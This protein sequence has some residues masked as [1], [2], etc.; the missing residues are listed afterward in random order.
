MEFDRLE[1]AYD[2][3]QNIFT[4]KDNEHSKLIMDKVSAGVIPVYKRVANIV[5][6][7]NNVTRYDKT[8]KVVTP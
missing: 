8:G 5:D 4:I 3:M 6:E 1:N 2:C 7:N